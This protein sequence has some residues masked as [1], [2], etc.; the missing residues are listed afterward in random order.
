MTSKQDL[1]LLKEEP[2]FDQL[3]KM[4]RTRYESLG[5]VGGAVCLQKFTDDELAVIS[6]FTGIS[7]DRLKEKRSLT[8]LQFEKELMS[9][10]YREFSLVGLLEAY[11]GEPLVIK[12]DRLA[13]KKAQEL[14]FL[15]R[16]YERFSQI[17][18]YIEWLSKRSSATSWV[19]G[20][21][22]QDVEGVMELLTVVDRSFSYF[23]SVDDSF[24]R[25]P[26]FAQLVTGNPHGLDRSQTAG[27]MLLHAMTVRQ[28]VLG[29]K[30]SFKRSVE[31]D[32]E[33]LGQYGLLR[34]DLWSFVTFQ[35]LLAEVDQ[36]IH[37]VWHAACEA[38]TTLNLPI[39]E[40]AKVN[41]VYPA[42]GSDVWVIENSSVASTIMD[43]KPRA[44][45]VCTHGQLRLA[46]WKLLD[47]LVANGVTIHYAG[48]LDPEG[49]LIADRIKIKYGDAVVLWRMEESTYETYLS[50]EPL[51]EERLAKLNM[52][53][54]PSLKR[55]G[56]FMRREKKAAYQEA[57]VEEMIGDVS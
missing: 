38:R 10:A 11:F 55:L 9:T 53:E 20:L 28:H 19:W 16:A 33:L 43:A 15:E 42:T 41:K 22:E 3:F 36:T 45:L 37:P 50:Q 24:W 12:T 44:P 30:L 56:E 18:W 34:D 52:L 35:N 46:S 13:Q 51:S 7:P 27:R 39:K 40:I 48:D 57:F 1:R 21:Y 23:E 54:S 14:A 6:G 17:P 25:L 31:E 32:N 29:N 4:L 26:L 5:R 2:V 8:L 49:L 47:F